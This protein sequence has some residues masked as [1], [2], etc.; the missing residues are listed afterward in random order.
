MNK[1]LTRSFNKLTEI[2]LPG[3]SVEIVYKEYLPEKCKI[4]YKN[5]KDAQPEKASGFWNAVSDF[6]SF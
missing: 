6:F 4:I 1:K 2:V 3:K 5:N